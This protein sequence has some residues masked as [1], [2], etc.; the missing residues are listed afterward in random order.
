MLSSS[1]VA[2]LTTGTYGTVRWMAYEQINVDEAQSSTPYTFQTDVWAF[3][4]TILVSFSPLT[5]I[6][7]FHPPPLL[8]LRPADVYYRLIGAAYVGASL[9]AP[10]DGPAGHYRHIQRST[11]AQAPCLRC[12]MECGTEASLG[13]MRIVLE[14]GFDCATHVEGR[15]D[16]IGC[17]SRFSKLKFYFPIGGIA[18]RSKFSEYFSLFLFSKR[19]L[20]V[21]IL[22][23]SKSLEWK[24][25]GIKP[26]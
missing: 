6:V 2:S 19:Y 3:G 12:R 4:M 18:L 21:R 26:G 14:S 15:H 16:E 8:L 1:T 13:R 25:A 10:S 23:W 9:R 11:S 7:I 17:Y 5:F 24:E 22:S 20:G